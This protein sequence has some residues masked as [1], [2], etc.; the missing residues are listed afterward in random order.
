M[1]DSVKL[2]IKRV[3]KGENLNYSV[4][5][6][7]KLDLYVIEV[8]DTTGFIM[9]I[10]GETSKENPATAVFGITKEEFELKDSDTAKLDDLAFELM[11]KLPQDRIIAENNLRKDDRVQ[12]IDDGKY[13]LEKT[14]DLEQK[15]KEAMDFQAEN[16]KKIIS[17][18]FEKE[19]GYVVY[20]KGA[21]NKLP[22]IDNSGAIQLFSKEEYAKNVVEK[23]PEVPL[24]ILKLD[25]KGLVLLF[26]NLFRYGVLKIK[27][28]LLQPNG[29]VVERDIVAKLGEL[30]EYQL[31]NSRCYS[32]MIRYLQAK[33]LLNKTNANLSSATLWS[34]FC[35]EFPKSLFF[36]PM[37]FEGEEGKVKDE[38]EIYFTESSLKIMKE[39]KPAILGIEKYKPA[40]GGGRKMR[41][42]TLK[43]N[44]AGNDKVFFP[45]FTDIGELKAVFGEK[46]RLCMISYSDLR[47]KYETCFGV[48]VNPASLNLII[49]D[50][51]MEN[52]EQEKDGPV[53]IYKLDPDSENN[54]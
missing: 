15:K 44:A 6:V 53:K 43:N 54:G 51:G 38:N 10:P 33:Q 22:T 30:K 46:A 52:I 49:T 34:A 23:A 25:K 3:F 36:V 1:S 20:T 29:G 32:L 47:E 5:I 16:A 42:I 41:F 31:L 50:K 11:H 45:I 4:G 39:T 27:V 21:G 12:S 2:T 35:K 7:E 28:D 19:E 13:V 9:G 37:C 26:Q 8:T 17:N 48:V 18:I 14:A 40:S 24:E